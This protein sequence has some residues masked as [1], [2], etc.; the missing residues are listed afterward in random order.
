ML[1]CVKRAFLRKSEEMLDNEHMFCYN[2]LIEFE[3][4]KHMMQVNTRR[5]RFNVV[6]RRER[7]FKRF[8]AVMFI[9][10]LCV[11]VLMLMSRVTVFDAAMQGVPATRLIDT[12]YDFA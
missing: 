8:V 10:S 11:L 2:P 1:S 3:G 4:D 12:P 9:L 7:S 5:R 6:S